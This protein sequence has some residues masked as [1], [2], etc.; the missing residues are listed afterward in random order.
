MKTRYTG[1]EMS[2]TS[3]VPNVGKRMAQFV[4]KNETR[5]PLVYRIQSIGTRIPINNR[6]VYL[7]YHP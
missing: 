6:L 1:S 7:V 5:V 2:C 4:A 3:R